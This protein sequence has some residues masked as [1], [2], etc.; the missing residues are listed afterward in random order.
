MKRIATVRYSVDM[1]LAFYS[2]SDTTVVVLSACLYRMCRSK[3]D[4][5]GLDYSMFKLI[6]IA[7]LSMGRPTSEGA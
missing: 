1:A 5:Y 4:C 2:V 3:T 6:A 7:L